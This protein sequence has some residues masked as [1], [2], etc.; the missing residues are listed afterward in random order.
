M[1]ID[2]A[3]EASSPSDLDEI[4]VFN[5]VLSWDETWWFCRGGLGRPEDGLWQVAVA[6]ETTLPTP[7]CLLFLPS[8]VFH[9]EEVG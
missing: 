8:M 4:L 1:L 5:L 9:Q 2:C 6:K 3:P 7:F